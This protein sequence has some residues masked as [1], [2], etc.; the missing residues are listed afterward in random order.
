[1]STGK[2]HTTGILKTKMKMKT[3]PQN[4]Q[5][6]PTSNSELNLFIPV[7]YNII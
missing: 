3:F 6:I 4:N 7:H 2:E 5:N 1:M